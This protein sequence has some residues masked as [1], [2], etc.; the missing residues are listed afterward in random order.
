MRLDTEFIKLPLLFDV[1]RL[2]QELDQFAEDE[3]MG[4]A[5]GFSGNLSIPLISLNGE[6]NDAL[7][8]PMRPTPA[9]G[10]CEY[11]Q[12][13]MTAFDEVF[14]R[15][16]LMRLEPGHDVP[17]HVDINYHWFNRVRVHIPITTT[18]DVRFF[19]ND[20]EL[21]MAAGECWIFDTW[22]EHTVRNQS[23]ASRVHLVLDTAGSP[24]FW[25]LAR[26]G[27]WPFASGERQSPEPR[28]VA[29]EPGRPVNIRTETYNAP[30]VL[31]PGEIDNLSRI[32]I[33]DIDP[34]SGSGA[35]GRDDFVVL[36]KSLVAAW[37]EVWSEHGMK[38]SGWPYYH[39]LV[40]G[41]KMALES[42]DPDLTLVSNGADLVKAFRGIVLFSAIN[43]EFAPQYLAADE[44]P[45][46]LR[47]AM[48]SFVD[49]PS[50]SQNVHD[51]GSAAEAATEPAAAEAVSAATPGRN[52]P[53]FCGSGKRYKNCHGSI[54]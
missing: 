33:D 48:R 10:R 27:V 1:E 12:Q 14:S 51:T 49:K 44:L 9:L 52:Q 30:L 35:Q 53:C 4:H 6:R 28:F 16:R 19:C 26:Q 43:E 25:E 22:Q 29:Y 54:A 17:P 21:H 2:R 7:H 5:T 46:K 32:L 8:G 11:I 37:R 45:A 34:A 40:N 13:I 18:E 24:R 31:S 23:D 42:I 50:G 47:Q 41:A 15:S 3:W 38:P 20:K 39:H 36:C